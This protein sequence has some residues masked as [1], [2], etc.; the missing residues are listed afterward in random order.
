MR[1]RRYAFPARPLA[2]VALLAAATWLAGCSR[3]TQPVVVIPTLS[4]VTISPKAD[5]LAVGQSA[6]FTATALD[7]GGHVVNVAFAWQ[8]LT[9]SVASVSGSGLVTANGQGVVR[10]VAT[11]GSRSDTALVFVTGPVAAWVVQPSGTVKNLYGVFFQPDGLTGVVVGDGGTV[12]TTSDAGASWA[13]R[14]G[15]TTSDLRSVWFTSRTVG[16]AVGTGG[17]LMTTTDGGA[18]WTR[19][20]S[21]NAVNELTCVRFA[22][23]L[24]GWVVGAGGL[25]ASTTDG[26][27]TWSTVFPTTWALHAVSFAGTLDGWAVGA[28][29]TALGTHDGGASWYLVPLGVTAQTLHGVWRANA[30]TAIAVG[31][32]GTV[33]RSYATT[34]SLA[35]AVGSTGAVQLLEAVHMVDASHGWAA[36]SDPNALVLATADGGQSWTPQHPGVSQ[37]LHGVYFTDS[38]TGWVVGSGGRIL[39][40]ASGGF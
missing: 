38:M 29:G 28:N 26:G 31:T 23:A 35:W 24:H 8:S 25:I 5:S 40:T 17:V 1:F 36:G 11:A 39:H 16:W 4:S 33:A 10:I 30:Q 2:A 9:P 37:A 20:T 7:T 18:S 22:D 34:D 3:S 13:I 12:L 19:Q 6:Q 14:P 27:A 21:I 32:Q 15:G